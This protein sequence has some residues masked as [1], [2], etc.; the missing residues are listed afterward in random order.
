MPAVEIITRTERRRK[1]TEQQREHILKEC[2]QPGVTVKSVAQRF[3]IS[4]S[5]LYSWRSAYRQRAAIEA[6]SQ[7]FVHFGEITNAGEP[8][9]AIASP[10]I[11]SRTDP[12]K[13]QPSM[14]THE[15]VLP[16][17]GNSPGAIAIQLVDG[18]QLKV[19]S[20]VNER[21]LLRVLKVLRQS[22]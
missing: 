21:A 12:V 6:Q 13:P 14:P 22:Q 18:T 11:P 20:F 2:E 7:A 5:I 19:D 4:E 17:P 1:W 3:D 8:A 9:P 10:A 15:A 16:H